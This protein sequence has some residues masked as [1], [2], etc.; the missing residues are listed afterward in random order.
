MQRQINLLLISFLI[1][2]FLRD[3]FA[4]E[5]QRVDLNNKLFNASIQGKI[6]RAKDLIRLGADVNAVGLSDSRPLHIAS[7]IIGDRPEFVKLLIE[8]GAELNPQ[9]DEGQTPMHLAVLY[10]RT[11]ALKVLL[12]SGADPTIEDKK[13]K[14]SID[15]AEDEGYK[16]IANLL[17]AKKEP[18]SENNQPN[19]ITTNQYP[20]DGVSKILCTIA[21]T[22]NP[23]NVKFTLKP[24]KI[25]GTTPAILKAVKIGD[26]TLMFKPVN[27]Q[28]ILKYL[29]VTNSRNHFSFDLDII[30]VNIRSKPANAKIIFDNKI[31]GVTPI[32]IPQVS[33]ANHHIKLI[34]EG[35]SEYE[36][37]SNISK[38]QRSIKIDLQPIYGSLVIFSTPPRAE[39]FIENER[40]GETPLTI[41]KILAKNHIV[42]LKAGDKKWVGNV[43]VRE[44]QISRLTHN[45][46][47]SY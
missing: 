44:N 16:E 32:T 38:E 22:S 18:T 12:Q 37:N 8:S 23:P 26:Y 1:A 42:A 13:G 28:G 25:T 10:G 20:A 5:D 27:S 45:F 40:Y 47:I 31:I 7:S 19:I 35:Y 4:L 43:E 11:E 9:N 30:D 15:Y 24:G 2:C 41:D 46:K 34:K 33:C 36:I 17:S 21:L 14:T 6:S 29:S 39:I 3:A